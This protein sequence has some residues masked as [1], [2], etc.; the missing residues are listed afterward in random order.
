[1]AIAIGGMVSSNKGRPVDQTFSMLPQRILVA[2]VLLPLG[3]LAIVAGGWILAAVITGMLAYAAWEYD[4]L[5]RVGG[6]QPCAGVLILGTAGTVLARHAF[7]FSGS[8]LLIGLLVIITM[9]IQVIAFEKGSKTSA[10]DFA[11]TIGGV[12]YLGWLGAYLIS[13]RSLPDGLWWMLLVFPA[14]LIGDAAA[15]FVGSRFGRHKISRRVSPKK[16]WEGYIGGIIVAGLGTML[17][18]SLWHNYAPAITLEKGLIV[19]LVI[20]ILAPL[21]DLGES[22]LKRTFGVKD[23]SHLLPGHGGMMDR[24]DSWLWAAPI[25]Y[26]LIVFLWV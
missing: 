26:Y 22:M 6:Y 11:I 18:A 25:G 8:D 2:A 16:S 24:M 7:Q 23:S 20:S 3:M 4:H 15:Y 9:A 5:F 12:L 21:G 10:L 17:L 14:I 13:L 19:G 1:M